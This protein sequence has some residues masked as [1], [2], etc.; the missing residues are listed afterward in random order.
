MGN[1]VNHRNRSIAESP[2]LSLSRQQSGANGSSSLACF[3]SVR[4]RRKRNGGITPPCSFPYF[5][6][7]FRQER[8]CQEQALGLPVFE[9]GRCRVAPGHARFLFRS[10][11]CGRL[12]PRARERHEAEADEA[13]SRNGGAIC[14][15]RQRPPSRRSASTSSS[16]FSECTP[17]ALPAKPQFDDENGPG[18]SFE[19]LRTRSRCGLLRC[20][21]G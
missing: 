16:R 3:L 6:A 19:K 17:S 5:R 1:D 8:K 13:L 10:R 15:G 20:T 7:E 14:C 9:R 11:R 4:R 21:Q 2:T 18:A 12:V